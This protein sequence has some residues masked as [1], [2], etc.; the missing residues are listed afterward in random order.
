MAA[1]PR[2]P[3]RYASS[4]AELA[5]LPP[6]DLAAFLEAVGEATSS[7]ALRG[8]THSIADQLSLDRKRT[9]EIASGLSDLRS[10]RE[11]LGFSV[12]DLVL[13]LQL[14]RLRSFRELSPGW[15]SYE[16][17][18]PNET[19][20]QNAHHILRALWES[21]EEGTHVARVRLSPSVEGGVGI[22]FG[23]AGQRYADIECFNDGEVLAIT[24]EPGTEPVVWSVDTEPGSLRQTFRRITAFLNG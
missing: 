16:A 7:L 11:G 22:I 12:R 24:S 5:R 3:D 8:L 10:T 19:A 18:P 15:D 17:D 20:L 6:E 14:A 21:E 2:I 13:E 4:L 23:A 1:R 9:S